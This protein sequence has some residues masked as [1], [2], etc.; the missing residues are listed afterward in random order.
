MHYVS[1]NIDYL[2]T[3]ITCS[4]INTWSSY[5][6]HHGIVMVLLIGI[7]GINSGRTM[8]V[9]ESDKVHSWVVVFED[10]R[11]CPDPFI[12]VSFIQESPISKH[13]LIH[14]DILSTVVCSSAVNWHN[15][16]SSLRLRYFSGVE[17]RR[18]CG[19]IYLFLLFD[20]QQQ[21]HWDQGH[22]FFKY[23]DL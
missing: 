12:T 1:V 20:A 22:T 3:N 18:E 15:W 14:C 8:K 23:S 11:H 10:I 16:F 21:L 17:D 9:W 13:L 7:W 4:N 19:R 6:G 2:N 5:Q